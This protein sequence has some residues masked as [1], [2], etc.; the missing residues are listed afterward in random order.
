MSHDHDHDTTENPFAKA[1]VHFWNALYSERAALW[2][3]NPNPQLVAEASDLLP[4]TALDVGCGEGAD[5][6]WL[7]RRG[8]K[9][10]GTDISSVALGRAAAHADEAGLAV[11][12]LEAD[13]TTWDP[14]GRSFDLVSAQFFHMLEPARGVLFRAL[15]ELVAPGGRLLIV[16]HHPDDSPSA[17]HRELLHSTDYVES[18]FTE[19]WTVLVSESRKRDVPVNPDMPHTTDTV[20]L[21][22]RI[23]TSADT[24]S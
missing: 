4:G 13:L 19:G 1:D 2:S 11:E 6:L 23:G 14:H 3:G 9:V 12:W 10:T 22:Q 20:V 5:A 16:G 24:A 17:H 7:A 15:G 18:L 8:W 21:L